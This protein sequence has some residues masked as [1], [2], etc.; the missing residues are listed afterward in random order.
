MSAQRTAKPSAVSSVRIISPTFVTPGR[1]SVPEFCITSR[2]SNAA[3]CVASASVAVR[4]RVSA[5]VS[6]ARAGAVVAKRAAVSSSGR[7]MGVTVAT[8]PVQ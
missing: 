7:I 5:G 2:S 8:M 1:L 4:M 3:S 6:D